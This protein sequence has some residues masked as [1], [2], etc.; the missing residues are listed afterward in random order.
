MENINIMFLGESHV[1]KT[2]IIHNFSYNRFNE[3]CFETIGFNNIIKNIQINDK[4]YRLN[5][6][7]TP[8]QERFRAVIQTYMRNIDI[9]IMVYDITNLKSFED[10]QYWLDRINQFK[11]GYCVIGVIGNK[12]DLNSNE[13]ITKEEGLKFLN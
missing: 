2:S 3:D 1:G 8:G 4:N 6:L 7:D 5:I 11:G 12:E 9:F 10:L 13:E